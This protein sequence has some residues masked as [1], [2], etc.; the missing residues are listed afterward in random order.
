MDRPV[1]RRAA[2]GDQHPQTGDSSAL[3]EALQC[4]FEP[5]TE[6]NL[7]TNPLDGALGYRDYEQ[8][9]I[10]AT[11]NGISNEKSSAFEKEYSDTIQVG[12]TPGWYIPRGN[13]LPN[14]GA[15]RIIDDDIKTTFTGQTKKPA[16]KP[17]PVIAASPLEVVIVPGQV[18]TPGRQPTGAA[19]R[20]DVNTLDM[21]KLENGSQSLK[22]NDIDKS[23]NQLQLPGQ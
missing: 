16:N 17:T 3:C 10:A 11:A 19:S 1:R 12:F 23:L 9:T 4:N 22:L 7:A 2:R 13:Y 21:L 14:V 20:K 6:L 15:Q 5:T 18:K 8:R